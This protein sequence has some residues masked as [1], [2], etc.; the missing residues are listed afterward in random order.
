LTRFPLKD[1]KYQTSAAANGAQCTVYV[2][3]VPA[4]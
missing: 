4:R 1:F 3:V 2:Y